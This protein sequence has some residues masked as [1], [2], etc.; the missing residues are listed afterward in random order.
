MLKARR[1]AKA[2]AMA[3]GALLACTLTAAPAGPGAAAQ[4]CPSATE[5]PIQVAKI[6]GEL[7]A[8]AVDGQ[9]RMFL[10]DLL[11]QYVW[12]IDRPGATP[13][14]LA[15]GFS[16]LGGIVVRPDGRL[17]VG[18]GNDPLVGTSGYLLPSA[19]I[20][21]VDPNTGAKSVFAVVRSADGL[22]QGPDGSVYASNLFGTSI[23]RIR[24]DGH[25]DLDWAQM[26]APNGLAVDATNAY[27]YAARSVV[28][29]VVTRIPIADPAAATN[30]AP[31]TGTDKLSVPDG[32]T[33]DSTGYPVVAEHLGQIW[34]VAPDGRLCALVTGLYLSSNVGYGRGETGFSKG[35]L[36]RI[37]F[38]GIVDE[39]PSGFDPGA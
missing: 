9:G 37:G 19:K 24:P 29:G 32:L 1:K 2:A 20:Y 27:L 12:R 4:A 34:R 23:A 25:V 18:S 21:L 33:L 7:E 26:P 3:A 38:D 13:V 28:D 31:S 35:R 5:A 17:L 16:S 11:N 14:L 22:A 6:S 8:L 36:F 10:T 15:K 39:L 30:F